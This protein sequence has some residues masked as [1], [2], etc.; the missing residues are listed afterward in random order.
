[1][2]SGRDIRRVRRANKMTQAKFAHHMG[3]SRRTVIRWERA[4]A[5]WNNYAFERAQFAKLEQPE[6]DL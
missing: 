5:D 3:V 1:M 6:L 4:G 2:Y